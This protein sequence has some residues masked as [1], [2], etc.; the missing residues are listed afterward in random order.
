MR[1]TKTNPLLSIVNEFLI[2]SPAPSSQ[3]YFWSFGSQL[4]LNLVV[5]IIT[6]V[7]LAMHYTPNTLLAFNSVEH[8][9]RDVNL[10]WLQRY[11]HANGA[12]FF[13]IFVYCHIGRGLY[14]GSYRAPRALLWNIGVIIYFQMM[15][16]AFIGAANGSLDYSENLETTLS[17]LVIEKQKSQ[18][19]QPEKCYDDLANQKVREQ[20]KIDNKNKAGV[21]AIVN[22]VNGKVYIGSAHYDQIW[23]RFQN[24]ILQKPGGSKLVRFAINLHGLDAFSFLIQAYQNE[25]YLKISVDKKLD[26]LLDLETFYILKFNAEYNIS[27]QAHSTKGV[28]H[29]EETKQLLKDLWT[30]EL[31]EKARR[32]SQALW[33]PEYR[34]Y[35]SKVL[36]GR[37]FSEETKT[38][39]KNAWTPERREMISK[40]QKNRIVSEETRKK[41]SEIRSSPEARERNSKIHKGKIVSD[42]A[43]TRIS[44]AAL[45]RAGYGSLQENISEIDPFALVDLNGNLHSRYPTFRVMGKAIGQS[46]DTLVKYWLNNQ[47]IKEKWRIKIIT[48]EEDSI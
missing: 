38:Q 21:Y 44:V 3:S 16:T 9:Q 29:S 17:P 4:G 5:M 43:S 14:Y 40:L 25:P 19:V 45:K 18:N 28:Q 48:I 33:T 15:G 27:K 22:N 46:K 1:I 26:Y 8:I 37:V 36:K 39:M 11:F 13:F 24:H 30:P 42:I 41:L 32:Q 31:K 2:D 35:M 6:G 12:S 7:Q 10:G 47:T 20:I 23:R 34:E